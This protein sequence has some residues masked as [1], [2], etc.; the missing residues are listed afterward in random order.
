MSTCTLLDVTYKYCFASML[1]APSQERDQGHVG[2][3]HVFCPRAFRSTLRAHDTRLMHRFRRRLTLKSKAR[4]RIVAVLECAMFILVAVGVHRAKIPAGASRPA[5][6]SPHISQTAT[7]C[8]S[9]IFLFSARHDSR[10]SSATSSLEFLDA[11][12]MARM[13]PN[14]AGSA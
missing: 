4:P 11:R 10:T 13:A 12:N 8:Y 9:S 6:N 1:E 2:V 14:A 3:V 5:T 7:S